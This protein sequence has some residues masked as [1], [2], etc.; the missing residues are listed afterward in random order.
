MRL[1]DMWRGHSDP[2]YLASIASGN[3]IEQP[4]VSG[5]L[6]PQQINETN[7]NPPPLATALATGHSLDAIWCCGR[8]Q[9]IIEVAT[10]AD[11]PGIARATLRTFRDYASIVRI[12]PQRTSAEDLPAAVVAWSRPWKI[13]IQTGSRIL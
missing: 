6:R 3:G 10:I 7:P 4:V 2:C 13:P 9:V 8:M 12:E 1:Y 5:S 11:G